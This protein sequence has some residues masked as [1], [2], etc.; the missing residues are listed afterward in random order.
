MPRTAHVALW[1]PVDSSRL[2]TRARERVLEPTN[3]V[4]V[5]APSVWEIAVKPAIGRG[6]IPVSGDEAF[7][8]FRR[9]GYRRLPV[10]PEHASAT[11]RLPPHQ[12]DPFDRLLVDSNCGTR[13]QRH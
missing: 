7:G 6:D 4:W 3:E 11:E 1:A 9:A 10:T 8:W 2:F 12:A 13:L 5:S